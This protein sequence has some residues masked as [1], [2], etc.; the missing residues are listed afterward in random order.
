MTL[1]GETYTIPQGSRLLVGLKST[2]LP[3]RR[4]DG[5]R[6]RRLQRHSSRLTRFRHR[7]MKIFLIEKELR[8]NERQNI[9]PVVFK[10]PK[11]FLSRSCYWSGY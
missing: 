9:D 11:S 4:L 10:R 8:R 7:I 1:D 2:L 3:L 5:T 6:S